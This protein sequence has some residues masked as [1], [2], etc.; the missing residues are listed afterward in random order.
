VERGELGP[1]RRTF[2]GC[3]EVNP[4]RKTLKNGKGPRRFEG[5]LV[6]AQD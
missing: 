4:S 3:E 2:C 5:L 1:R 6:V